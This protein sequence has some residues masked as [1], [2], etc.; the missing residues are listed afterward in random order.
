MCVTV[1]VD[2]GVSVRVGVF[3]AAL[4]GVNVGEA[5]VV[6]VIDGVTGVSVVL[7]VT[8]GVKGSVAVNVCV[9]G[10]GLGVCVGG[11]AVDV[12]VGLTVGVVDVGLVVCVNVGGVGGVGV[13]AVPDT[14]GV[15]VPLTPGVG[16]GDASAEP[17]SVGD[18]EEVADGVGDPETAGDT[19]TAGVGVTD[20]VSEIAA[21]GVEVTVGLGVGGAVVISIA[22]RTT[23]AALR[24]PSL[25]TSASG[26][27]LSPKTAATTP[28]ISAALTTPLQS[29]SPGI[30]SA[31]VL[32]RDDA[33]IAKLSARRRLCRCTLRFACRIVPFGPA[34]MPVRRAL[35]NA[36]IHWPI[37]CCT[38][39]V[40]TGVASECAR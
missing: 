10:S 32:Q 35:C 18:T 12:C 39:P 17:V 37:R 40:L 23:S 28:R 20:G 3:V 7:G 2:E 34:V 8:V 26:Q 29:A 21:V 6:G 36:E 11:T 16:V 27:E 38:M 22:S 19:D 30:A 4:L 1:G 9:G 25:F 14:V 13:D 5:G 33:R 31:T 15:L 24:R